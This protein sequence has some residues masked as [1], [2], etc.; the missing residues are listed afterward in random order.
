MI[1]HTNPIFW[2]ILGGVCAN[3]S[4]NLIKFPKPSSGGP[5]A[6]A[7]ALLNQTTDNVNVEIFIIRLA[8]HQN[9]LLQQLWRE[10]DEQSLPPQ[11]RR[12]L[13]AQGFRVGILGNLLSPALAQLLNVSANGRVDVPWGEVH[14]ISVADA[15]REPTVTRN[16]R[17]LLPTMSALVKVFDTPLPE[18]SL[19]REENGMIHGQTYMDVIGVLCVSA[20]ANK[21]GSA[22]IQIIPELEHGVSEL[23]VRPVAGMVVQETSRPRHSFESLTVSQR[24][25]P[26]HWLIMGVTTPDSAGSGKT[27][28]VRRNSGL[29]QRLLAIR[30]LNATH[31]AAVPSSTLQTMQQDTE[32]MMPERN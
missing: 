28:F 20:T 25:L 30:L 12:E 22:Q 9:E 4:C 24:L 3:L 11:L 10:V 29:E 32:V 17:N 2:L 18:Q 21:D 6:N 16:M 26:G 31:V 13:F 7:P 23:R 19:F 5:A 14:E 27:F 15:A 8:P 1:K